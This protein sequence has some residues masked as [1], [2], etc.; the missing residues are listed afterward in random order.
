M[1]YRLYYLLKPL[2]PRRIQIFLRRIVVFN[3]RNKYKNIW[4]IDKS[5]GLPPEKWNGWPGGKKFALVLTHD[6]DTIKGHDKCKELVELELSLGF[7]SSFNFVPEDYVVSPILRQFIIDKGFE[8]GVHG[9]H[10]DGKLYQSKESFIQSAVKINHYL[11]KWGSTGFRSPSMQHRLDWIH[12][13]NIEYDASTFDTDPFEPQSD[14]VGSIFP[15]CVS[16]N[17]YKKGYVELPYTLPQDFTLF[18]L[19]KESKIEIWKEKLDWVAEHGGMVLLN[20]HPDYMN[21]GNDTRSMEEY[22]VK[23]YKDFLEDITLRYKNEYWH[24]LPREMA[25]FWRKYMTQGL[26]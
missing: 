13:L 12:E 24:V 10:H 1:M 15:F 16:K 11:E 9:L 8:V 20:T 6:V 5:A 26:S 22:P 14:G 25:R 2:I 21:F 3:R 19:M 4:P 23:Y 18:I 7:R 17:N